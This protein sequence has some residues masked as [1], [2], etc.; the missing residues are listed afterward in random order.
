MK[1]SEML[2][3]IIIE[4]D[5]NYPNKGLQTCGIAHDILF[6]IEEKGMLPPDDKACSCPDCGGPSYYWDSE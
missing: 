5:K 2:K 4:L 6:R 1:R 3:V